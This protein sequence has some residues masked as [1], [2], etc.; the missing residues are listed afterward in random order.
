M[1]R[2][3]VITTGMFFFA[4]AGEGRADLVTVNNFGDIL[5]WAGSGSNASALVLQFGGEATPTSVAWGYRWND[6][7]EPEAAVTAADMVFSLTGQISGQGLPSPAAG[8]DSRLA[9]DAA[10][11]EGLG[12]FVRSISYDQRG[13][14]S[15]WSQSVR[16]MANDF[17]NDI[18]I[19]FYAAVSV[20]ANS[21]GPWPDAGLLSIAG[22]GMEATPLASGGWYGFVIQE[23]NPAD[24]SFPETFGFSQPV[25]A[26]PEPSSMVLLACAGVVV[27]V[28]AWRRRHVRAA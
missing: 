5:F 19:A 6:P 28:G 15:P 1:I 27:G 7:V 20:P 18:G 25:A 9:I 4:L 2:N 24:F 14:P 26:V 12:Y 3:L 16:S 23:Y 17:D 8:S 10:F 22:Q 13:L 11:F 21:M